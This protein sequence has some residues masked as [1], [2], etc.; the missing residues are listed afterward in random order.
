MKTNTFK[1]LGLLLI[2]FMSAMLTSFKT[3][4]DCGSDAFIDKCAPSLGEYTF[5]KTFNIDVNK[6]GDKFEFSYVFS[7]GSNYRIVICDQ[8]NDGN[9]MIVNFYDRN[10]KLIA[11]NYLKSAKKFFPVLNYTCSA[12][13]VYYVETS[14]EG[15]KSGCGA[16]ILGFK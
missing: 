3:G 15:G 5:I 12:T 8:N 14:F 16:N 2:I 13:G 7:K 11:S 1:A 4:S 10:K 6:S 9:R